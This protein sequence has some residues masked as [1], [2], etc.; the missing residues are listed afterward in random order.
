MLSEARAPAPHAFERFANREC[1]GRSPFYQ[2]LALGIAGD[3]ELLAL[4]AHARPGQPVSNLMLGAVQYLL[5]QDRSDPLAR[6]YPRLDELLAWCDAH[7]ARLEW[8]GRE[9]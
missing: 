9:R 4:S 2:R 8:L 3:R 1:E 6:F 5:L 7:G